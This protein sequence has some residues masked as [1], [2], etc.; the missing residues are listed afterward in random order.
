MRDQSGAG[1]LWAGVLVL[2]AG[3][4][5]CAGG[6]GAAGSAGPAVTTGAPIEGREG[7]FRAGEVA[8]GG[9]PEAGQFDAFR[10]EGVT[11]VINLRSRQEMSDLLADEGLDESAALGAAGM[12]YVHIPLGGDDGYEPADV[13]AFAEAV[14]GAPGPVLIH[15]ASGG[16]ARTMWQAYLV[17]HRGY[18]L[19]EAEAVAASIGGTPTALEQLLGRDVRTSLGGSLPASTP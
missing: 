11:T 16:R 19:A 5:G 3:V 18:S 12:R 4:G 7:F 13:E 6:G 15:C 9:Q 17:K 8:F 14:E 1:A 2:V 10:A